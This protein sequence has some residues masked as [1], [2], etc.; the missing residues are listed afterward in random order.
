MRISDWS[1][2]VCSSDLESIVST[3]LKLG[4][5]AGILTAVAPEVLYIFIFVVTVTSS[6][7]GYKLIE[8]PTLRFLRTRVRK[9]KDAI[10]SEAPR[11]KSSTHPHSI[12]KI[13]RASY[14]ERVGQYV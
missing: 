14:R 4:A 10:Q 5:K 11:P 9:W 1:S 7:V 3:L 12:C 8:A 6:I 13:G 2:D